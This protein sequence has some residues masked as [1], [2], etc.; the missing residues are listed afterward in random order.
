MLAGTPS[1]G[2]LM[3]LLIDVEN[4][5]TLLKGQCLEHAYT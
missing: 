2:F 5:T 4:I 3:D 1:R